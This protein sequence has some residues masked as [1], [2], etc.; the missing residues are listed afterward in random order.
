M[1]LQFQMFLERWK[2]RLLTATVLFFPLALGLVVAFP[3]VGALICGYVTRFL[4][5]NLFKTS[6]ELAGKLAIGCFA[7]SIF[8]FDGLVHFWTGS[9][10]DA[11]HGWEQLKTGIVWGV[12]VVWLFFVSYTDPKI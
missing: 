3:L 12:A 5:S 6:E 10:T 4:A 11:V 8:F 1:I 7:F 9:D 2:W